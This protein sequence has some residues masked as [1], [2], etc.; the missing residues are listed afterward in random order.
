MRL[1]FTYRQIKLQLIGICLFTPVLLVLMR[2][3][4]PALPSSPMQYD[5]FWARKIAETPQNDI[6]YVGDSR[7][8]R[9]INAQLID[10]VLN[11]KGFNFG[12][13]AAGLDTFLLNHAVLKLK[14]EGQKIIVLGLSIN[15]LLNK[16]LQNGHYHSLA[17][18]KKSDLFVR[19]QF[20]PYLKFADP[21]D[22]SDFYNFYKGEKYF[23]K[24][25][26]NSGFVASNKVPLDSTSA[27]KAYAEQFKKAQFDEK[28]FNLLLNRII[29]LQKQG[30]RFY[31][32]RMP[33]TNAMLRLEDKSFKGK[34][35]E[36]LKSFRI[37][38]VKIIEVSKKFISYDGS[39]L[40]S[41]S[42]GRL[43][44]MIAENLLDLK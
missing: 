27:L 42:A 19:S 9:G 41:A 14:P 8:Y 12:F 13:S 25:Y 37:N 36:V 17:N 2:L 30:Y 10:S 4:L 26:P 7:V 43:S 24:F 23:E 32:L 29:E 5:G 38:N 44:R 18:L 6:V 39:H 28:N 33:C 21:Y 11:T 31:A 35:D 22:L 16:S 3:L 40:T 20:Y 15:E 34:M 1:K